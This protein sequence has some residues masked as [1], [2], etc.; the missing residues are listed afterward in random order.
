MTTELACPAND[1][2]KV[3]NSGDLVLREPID[4]RPNLLCALRLKFLSPKRFR[5]RVSLH[6]T[7]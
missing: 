6:D 2:Q 7:R 1:Q 5:R 3:R 4:E